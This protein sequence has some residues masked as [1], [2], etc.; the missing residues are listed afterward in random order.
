LDFHLCHYGYVMSKPIA[1]FDIDGTIFR[2]SLLI[3]LT[4]Q[5]IASG[6]FPAAIAKDYEN[7]YLAWLN[8]EASYEIYLDALVQAFIQHIP[9]VHRDQLQLA[10]EHVISAMARQTYRYTRDL[11]KSLKQSHFLI[12]ISG[13]PVELVS[14]FVQVYGFDDCHAAVFERHND[15]FTGTVRRGDVNKDA[16]LRNMIEK[17]NLTLKGSV[18]VGDTESDAAFLKMVERPIA[19]NP[20]S[21]LFHI[22]SEK[23]WQ[24][25]VERKDVIYY[26]NQAK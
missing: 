13:S 20:N 2:S 15:R 26:Y 25:V 4:N 21:A 18:G 12:A 17:H 5:L 8:R 6:A 23:G 14:R 9:N 19:F 7:H 22:A 11:I 10:G 3:E 16:T 24:I 1:V